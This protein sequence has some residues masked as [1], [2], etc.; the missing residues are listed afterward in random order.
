MAYP[1]PFTTA[2]LAI[3]LGGDE[4]LLQLVD[5]QHTE[6]ITSASCVAFIDEIKEAAAGELYSILQ[7]VFDPA[8][9]VFQASPHVIQNALT[10]GVYWAWHKSTGGM[11]IPPEVKEAKAEA[12]AALKEA[13][14]GL[15]SLGTETDPTSNAGVKQVDIDATGTRVL[16]SNMGG[17]C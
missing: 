2:K 12:V 9:A 5:K 7:V 1:S 17:Y 13:R 15:R 8:D 16:R 10:V 6:D 4:K 3:A 14:T 11:A